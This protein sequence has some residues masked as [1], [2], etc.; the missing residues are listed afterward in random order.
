MIPGH[1][2]RSGKSASSGSAGSRVTDYRAE[3]L[4]MKKQWRMC[5][6]MAFI[7]SGATLFP[8]RAPRAVANFPE[9]RMGQLTLLGTFETPA[10]TSNS[11]IHDRPGGL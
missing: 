1:K 7:K 2:S 11:A 10:S 4:F 6:A 3:D 8:I 9:A 5:S